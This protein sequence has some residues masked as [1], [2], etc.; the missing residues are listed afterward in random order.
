MAG[1]NR[2]ELEKVLKHYKQ[3]PAD[4]LKFRAAEF[5]IINMPGKYSKYYDAPWN[6]IATAYL[7]WS[8]SSNKRLLVYTYGLGEP[9]V[10]EDVKYITG[11]YLINNIELAFKVWQEQPWGKHISFDVFCEEIL[12]YRVATE[13]LENW[14][15]KALASFA[16]LNR[17]FK[18]QPNITTIYACSQVN[19]ILPRF[20]LDHDFPPMNYSQSMATARS[21][22]AGMATLAVFAMRALGIPVTM[23]CT[24]YWVNHDVGHIWNTVRDSTGIHIPFMGAETNPGRPLRTP[25]NLKSKTYRQ[26]FARQT[27]ITADEADIPPSLRSAYVLD[28]SGEYGGCADVD[29]PMRFPPPAETRNVYLA[30]MGERTWNIVGWGNIEGN[31]EGQRLKFRSVGTSVLYV[32]LYYSDNHTTSA[33]SPFMLYADSSIHV[34]ALD[35]A[36]LQTIS[37]TEISPNSRKWADRM[38]SGVFEGANRED[39]SDARVLHVIRE[40]SGDYF[41]TVKIKNTSGFRYFR[42]VSPKGSGEINCNVAEI[43]LYGADGEQLRGKPIGTPGVWP[44]NPTMTFEKAFDNDVLTYYD[45]DSN[46]SWTGLDLGSSQQISE[47]HYLPR[48]DGFGIYEGHVYELFYWNENWQSLGKKKVI[49]YPLQYQVPS[50]ALFYL[51]NVTMHKTEMKVFT[52]KEGEVSW[53]L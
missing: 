38:V 2:K 7:R 16:D 4:S 14:R 31:I 1:D 18:E 11:E 43:K 23:D 34:F 24:P 5:L 51:E 42:Y 10:E 17:S 33:G 19:Y 47:I 21:S 9:V 52:V 6:D 20:R 40:M 44:T 8:S 37:L 12:P 49:D 48:T 41:S 28:V 32:P 22:C 30:A 15:E 35:T 53:D 46:N 36:Q 29:V 25:F 50:N 45:A 13:K 39:F 3:N 26:T 27:H